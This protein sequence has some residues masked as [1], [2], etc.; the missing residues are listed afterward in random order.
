[1]AARQVCRLVV[2]RRAGTRPN[3]ARLRMHYQSRRGRDWA[4]E[5]L[6]SD[7]LAS[8]EHRSSFG[9]PRSQACPPAARP[10]STDVADAM[11]SYAADEISSSWADMAIYHGAR[12]S[13]K[14]QHVAVLVNDDPTLM[15]H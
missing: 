6:K 4:T 14:A 11:L 2:T 5:P 8:A 10:R 9:S 1:M 3:H 15:S 7:D 13:L 12:S